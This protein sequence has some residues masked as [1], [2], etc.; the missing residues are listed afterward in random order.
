MKKRYTLK[1]AKKIIDG[2]LLRGNKNSQKE[3]YK[4]RYGRDWKKNYQSALSQ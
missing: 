3:L 4:M 2:I 1:Q